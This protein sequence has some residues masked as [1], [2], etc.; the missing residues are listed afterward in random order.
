MS[1]S[2][3]P[4]RKR[5]PASGH[6]HPFFEPCLARNYCGIPVRAFC[7]HS[8]PYPNNARSLIVDRIDI[9]D[10]IDRDAAGSNSGCGTNPTETWSDIRSPLEIVSPASRCPAVRESPR[11]GRRGSAS[12]TRQIYRPPVCRPPVIRVRPASD[13]RCPVCGRLLRRR[14]AAAAALVIPRMAADIQ[15]KRIVMALEPMI[16]ND[17]PTPFAEVRR[18][19]SEVT[20]HI[21]VVSVMEMSGRFPSL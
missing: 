5:P 15:P 12:G 2:T 7:L 8:Q 20:T 10:G 14:S 4:R 9:V 17:L 1:R 21:D 13:S 6:R 19:V 18:R 11:I 3:H 16:A